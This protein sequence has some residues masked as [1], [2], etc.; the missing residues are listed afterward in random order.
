MCLRLI[1]AENRPKFF[2]IWVEIFSNIQE[3]VVLDGDART[4]YGISDLD[5]ELMRGIFAHERYGGKP[6]IG[7]S[8]ILNTKGESGMPSW[9]VTTASFAA[10]M[11]KRRQLDG[12]LRVEI[13][14]NEE[15][16]P[17]EE[18][19]IVFSK[20]FESIKQ[21]NKSQ[22]PKIRK[23]GFDPRFLNFPRGELRKEVEAVRR[24][25][26]EYCGRNC[27]L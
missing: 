6:K 9:V 13:I 18:D 21:F 11:E 26:I 15:L 8:Q 2:S 23:L 1:I 5:A 12:S 14:Q 4:L 20:V 16:L 7:E 27:E 3:V 19:Y 17:E 22:E 10:H 24:A 25:Y